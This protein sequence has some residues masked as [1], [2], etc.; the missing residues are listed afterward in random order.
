MDD[1]SARWWTIELPLAHADTAKMEIYNAVANATGEP[2][3]A[4]ANYA[5]LL[6]GTVAFCGR[7]EALSGINHHYERYGA[8]GPPLFN[9]GPIVHA[10][11]Y[12][13]DEADFNSKIAKLATWGH[14]PSPLT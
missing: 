4:R 14:R 9:Q 12:K 5:D 13:L 2:D 7:P 6:G 3:R 10:R 11:T 8:V 1:L